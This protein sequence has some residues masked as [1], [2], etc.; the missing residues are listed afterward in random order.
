MFGVVTTLPARQ[1]GIQI[2]EQTEGYSLPP[3]PPPKKKKSDQIWDQPRL[4]FNKYRRSFLAVKRP[5]R[6]VHS[7]PSSAEVKDEWSCTCSPPV[8]LHGL[9]NKTFSFCFTCFLNHV[10]LLPSS[11]ELIKTQVSAGPYLTWSYVLFLP[12]PF[13]FI[14]HD[15]CT[16]GLYTGYT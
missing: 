14:N 5:E 13:Y 7:F 16:I 8:C 4:L 3:P 15:L 11:T 10:R 9:Y 1:S 2:L 12:H 6:D